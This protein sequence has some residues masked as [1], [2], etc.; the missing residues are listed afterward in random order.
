MKGKLI[1]WKFLVLHI[2]FEA[3][4]AILKTQIN[5]NL[6]ECLYITRI[7]DINLLIWPVIYRFIFYHKYIFFNLNLVDY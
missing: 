2:T 3:P 1:I 5:T 4:I 6:F 7:T